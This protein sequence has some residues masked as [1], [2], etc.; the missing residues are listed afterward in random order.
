MARIAPG[1]MAMLNK[2]HSSALNPRNSVARIK[3]PVDETGRYSVTPSTMPRMMTSNSIGMS[4]RALSGV[5][6]GRGETPAAAEA[7]EPLVRDRRQRGRVD[8]ERLQAFRL[9]RGD[10]VFLQH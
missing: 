6:G 7:A 4:G 9:G 2:A 3:W 10:I 5:G 1:W 8:P